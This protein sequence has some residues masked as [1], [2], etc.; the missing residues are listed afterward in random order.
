[1]SIQHLLATL[2]RRPLISLSLHPAT[3]TSGADL[4]VIFIAG[5]QLATDGI[6]YTREGIIGGT[7][8]FP[9][10]PE[11]DWIKEKG[12]D[13]TQFEAEVVVTGGNEDLDPTSSPDGAGIFTQLG[14]TN[15]EW[16]I[17]VNGIVQDIF[18]NTFDVEVR[19]IAEP[20]NFAATTV[21][22]LIETVI[23]PGPGL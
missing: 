13:L 2:T 19:E 8:L 15:L 23:G 9:Q 21:T 11:T 14:V 3:A 16:F 6:V 10:F 5:Y 22:L 17:S 20:S 18:T 7:Q 1:M 12:F 4:P